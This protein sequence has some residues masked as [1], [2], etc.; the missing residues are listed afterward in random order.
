MIPVTGRTGRH[1]QTA[2][3]RWLVIDMTVHPRAALAARAS[4]VRGP[5]LLA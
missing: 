5:S 3:A 1:Q 4:T 2:L